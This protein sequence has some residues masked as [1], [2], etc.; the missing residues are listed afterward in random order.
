MNDDGISDE[1]ARAIRDACYEL[2]SIIIDH[3][4]WKRSQRRSSRNGADLA[5]DVTTLQK[6][7]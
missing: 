5:D 7:L 6:T 1:D 4:K 2:A 3:W